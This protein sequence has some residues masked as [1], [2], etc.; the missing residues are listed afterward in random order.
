MNTY[1]NPQQIEANSM[2]IVEAH[3]HEYYGSPRE[4]WIA[5]RVVH[6]T[7][8]PSLAAKLVFNWGD[9]CSRLPFLR[10]RGISVY[11]DVHMLRCGVSLKGKASYPL[12]V[13]CFID[14]PEV[15]AM[16]ARKQITRAAAAMY[17]TGRD[18][19]NS[20]LAI[21][22]SPTALLA[23]L[24]IIEQEQIQPAMIIGAPVGFVGAEESK[25]LL[26]QRKNPPYVALLGKRGGS[27]VAAAIVNA[28]LSLEEGEE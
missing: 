18:L 5:K 10:E 11:T 28:L 25:T 24:D 9:F 22:N 16:A 20:L 23:V 7:A 19:D 13:N 12:E 14:Y 2:E 15:K 8:D 27:P 17:W 6:A 4:K 3:L 21:G 1:W 26:A